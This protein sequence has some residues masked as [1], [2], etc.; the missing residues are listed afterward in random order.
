MPKVPVNKL[1]KEPYATII[2][3]PKTCKTELTRRLRQLRK[4]GITALEFT[5]PKQIQNLNVQGKGCVGIVTTAYRK[6]EKIALKIRRTD[7]DRKTMLR[8]A[9]LL[10]KA[11]QANI[12]PTLLDASKN[13][14]IMQFIEGELLPQ[15][16]QK[17]TNQT[18]KREVFR[19]ILEQCRR[20]DM[21]GLDHGELSH[22]PKHIIIDKKNNS[23]LVDFETASLNRRPSNVT[24]ICQY[25]FISKAQPEHTYRLNP[26]D[27][28]RLINSLKN[29][30]KNTTQENYMKIIESCGLLSNVTLR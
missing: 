16:L 28:K 30:K 8:E 9:K 2:C 6:K 13:F 17:T 23:V 12:G 18:L 4:L 26:A 27:Q 24:S 21:A 5:G 15:W 22:A 11:N 29:Y 7:A 19:N 25:L 3:Y 14:L 1:T 20:L 10:K